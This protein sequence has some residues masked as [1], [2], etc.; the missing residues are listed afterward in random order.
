CGCHS[1]DRKLAAGQLDRSADYPW[2]AIE[3]LLPSCMAQHNNRWGRRC[4]VFRQDG[5]TQRDDAAEHLKIIPGDRVSAHPLALKPSANLRIGDQLRE[6][7]IAGSHAVILT[8]RKRPKLHS[9]R[10]VTK[11]LV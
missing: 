5:S 4:V 7:L 10:I 11:H 9:F 3:R 1:D 2:V 8:K 6:Y